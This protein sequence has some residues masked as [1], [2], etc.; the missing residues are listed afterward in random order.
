MP[1]QPIAAA[2]R[3]RER[4]IVLAAMTALIVWRSGVLVFWQETQFDADQ[5]VIGLMAKHL[6]EGRAFPVFMYGQSYILGVEAWMAAPLFLLVAASVTALK[7]PLLCINAA[8]ALLLV[9]LF[10]REAGL[11]P[12]LA[13]AAAAPFILPAPGTAAHL[14]DASAAILEPFLYVILLWPARRRPWL[15]GLIFGLGSLQ[16]ESTD[17]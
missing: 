13:A 12:A 14:L 5:A 8:V 3:R 4:W 11:R 6:S 10:E 2:L 9:R 1:E 17:Y 16:R 7:L 15:C